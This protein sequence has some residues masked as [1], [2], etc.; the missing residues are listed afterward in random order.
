MDIIISN[1]AKE[2]IKTYN[3]TEKIVI[4]TIK[5]P[6]E[7]IE[8]YAGTLISHKLLNEHI[9]RVIY[10]KKKDKIKIITVYPAKKERYYKRL[11]GFK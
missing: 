3:L 5:D 11:G 2:R 6:D 7:I 10:V 8:G 4:E 9:L 1:H